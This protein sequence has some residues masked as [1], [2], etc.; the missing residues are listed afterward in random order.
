MKGTVLEV[1]DSHP[2]VTGSAGKREHSQ[3]L[4]LAHILTTIASCS[5][6]FS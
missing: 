6:E 5:F 3:P 2:T 4:D 1:K